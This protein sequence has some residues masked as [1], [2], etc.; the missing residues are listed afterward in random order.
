MGASEFATGKLSATT[1]V[2]GVNLGGS[3][4][5]MLANTV[6]PKVDA[7]LGQIGLG[8]LLGG[9]LRTDPDVPY[10]YFL[11]INGLQCVR[12]KEVSGLKMTTELQRMRE[13]GNNIHEVVMIGPQKFEPLTVK[14]GFYS[15]ASEF[16]DWMRSIHDAG[17]GLNSKR[18]QDISLVVLNT[19]SVEVCRFNFTNA[20]IIEYEAP[21]FNA[22]A[23]EIAFESIKI[24]YDTFE[25]KPAAFTD[26]LIGGALSAGMSALGN[27]L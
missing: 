25:F 22:D 21:S 5:G 10:H 23:K 16:F 12:F 15:S 24:H 14:K 19:K 6:G 7:L 20:F 9:M 13:G 26:K 8:G 4:G 3:V 11:E 27:A 1:S 18:R 17:A 2:K